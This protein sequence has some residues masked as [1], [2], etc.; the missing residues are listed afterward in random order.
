MKYYNIIMK[1]ENF[2]DKCMSL[3]KR[4]WQIWKGPRWLCE[5][6]EKIIKTHRRGSLDG[7]IVW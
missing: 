7:A 4:A 1:Y 6:T 5:V 2:Y 3:N